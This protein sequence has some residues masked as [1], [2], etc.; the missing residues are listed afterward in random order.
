MIN[1]A[2]EY[3]E[4]LPVFPLIPND[5]K[6]L[7]KNGFN[8]A[9]QDIEQI[10]RWWT[11]NPDANIGVVSAPNGYVVLDVDTPDDTSKHQ[12]PAGAHTLSELGI[13]KELNAIENVQFYKTPSGGLH[14][15]FK[16]D[17]KILLEKRHTGENALWDN[18]EWLANGG[19]SIAPPSK[20]EKGAYIG[21]FNIADVPDI[22]EWLQSILENR[23]KEK[24]KG[25]LKT[26]HPKMFKYRGKN[27]TGNLL[28]K[29][30]NGAVDGERNVW[31]TSVTGSLLN[32]GMNA[33]AI[34][35]FL[36]DIN[37][38]YIQPPLPAK[39]VD[40]IFNSIGKKYLNSQKKGG[41]K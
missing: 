2:L 37:Q 22:P 16:T 9:T 1:K 30:V 27:Y 25:K 33:E 12:L 26:V 32:T 17:S 29:I 39:T 31:L 28:D 11:K 35:K 7:T 13:W 15:W 21:V 8:N 6:P 34:Y 36:H 24:D 14:Y 18:V 5:K 20:T 40:T 10:K 41:K 19:Y 38:L 4:H 3:A 23:I